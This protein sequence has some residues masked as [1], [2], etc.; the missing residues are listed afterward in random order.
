MT[1]M[2]PCIRK[3]GACFCVAC[4]GFG[5]YTASH[6]EL[7]ETAKQHCAPV[8]HHSDDLPDNEKAI[9]STA[10]IILSGVSTTAASSWNWV[11]YTT[12][13]SLSDFLIK[14]SA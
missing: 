12:N 3:T 6:V 13:M 9:P 4:C 7:C 8:A 5:L 14:R 11:N 10:K 2:S 1:I